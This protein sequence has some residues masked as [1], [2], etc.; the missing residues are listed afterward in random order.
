M[1]TSTIRLLT[2]LCAASLISAAGCGKDEVRDQPPVEE[3]VQTPSQDGVQ[4][5]QAEQMDQPVRRVTVAEWEVDVDNDAVPDMIGRSIIGPQGEKSCLIGMCAEAKQA[6]LVHMPRKVNTIILLDASGSM[7]GKTSDG[8]TKMDAARKAI[9]KFVDAIPEE[10]VF[11]TGLVVFGHKGE[12]TPEAK[13]ESCDAVEAMVPLGS[14]KQKD[15]IAALDTFE[16]SGWTPIEPALQKAA[17]MVP[18]EE[19]V[20]NRILIVSDG[21]ERCGGDPVKSAEGFVQKG[22][23]SRIDVI[24]FE[25]DGSTDVDVDALKEMAEIA[26]QG[27]YVAAS[28]AN[29]FNQAFVEMQAN[30][31]ATREAWLCGVRNSDELQACYRQFERDATAAVREQGRN[32]R[33]Q[34]IEEDEDFVDETVSAI[35]TGVDRLVEEMA[36]LGRDVGDATGDAAGGVKE[37]LDELGDEIDEAVE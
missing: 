7:A 3:S 5:A 19:F 33:V 30:L 1:K 32:I 12:N 17:D 29:Q 23:F 4:Q 25:P 20:S 21:I 6:G 28:N 37:E 16:P 15:I 2:G 10:Q 24:G 18:K 31:E 36:E 14:K 22:I 26:P 27:S 9:R 35:S 34:G 11:H 13:P 8:T